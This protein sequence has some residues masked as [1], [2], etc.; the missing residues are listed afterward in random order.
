MFK[1][2][3]LF[4][5]LGTALGGAGPYAGTMGPRDPYTDGG[6]ATKF[7]V[8]TDGAAVTDKRDVFS[9][10]ARITNRDGYNDGA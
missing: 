8:Y 2:L 7:D 6:K 9:D 4:A 5:A 10:G 3:V 1:K